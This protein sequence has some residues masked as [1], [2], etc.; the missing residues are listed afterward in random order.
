MLTWIVAIIIG[1]GVL[2]SVFSSN[3]VDKEKETQAVAEQKLN[4]SLTPEQRAAEEKKKAEETTR[5]AAAATLNNSRFACEEFVKRTLHDPDSAQFDDYHDYW[6]KEEKPGLF[7]VQVGLR[8]RNGF[9]ALRQTTVDCVSR[10][11]GKN[12]MAVKLKEIN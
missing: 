12:W 9:N 10:Y 3:G 5:Q 11:D 1:I 7:H 6:A 8:A 2:S 4:A